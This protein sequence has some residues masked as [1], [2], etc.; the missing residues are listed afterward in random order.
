[1]TQLNKNH[2]I[3]VNINYEDDSSEKDIIIKQNKNGEIRRNQEFIL[4][5]SYGND[6]IEN[7]EMIDLKNK[8]LF[9]GT[10]W[11]KR[12]KIKYSLEYEFS[13]TIERNTIIK[14]NIE[15]GENIN[16]NETSV[17]ITISKGKAIKV[18]NLLNMKVEDITNWVMENKLKISFEEIYDEK[19]ET[20]KVIKANVNE[21]D[22]I[23][24]GFEIILTI[25]KGQIKMQK[26]NSLY[27]FKEWAN[28]YNIAYSESYEYS[29]TVSKGSVISYSYKE[30]EIIN[31][32]DVIY[33]KVSLGKSI[34]IPSFIGKTK[35]EA[36]NI[37][38]SIGIRC[39]FTTGTYTNYNQNVVY[40]QSKNTGT[41]VGSGASITLT[42]SKGI[43]Q[44]K[45]LSILQNWISIGNADAT[46]ASLK[47][48]FNEYY[49]GVNFNFIKVKDNT[50]N[51][52]MIAKNSPTNS[53]TPVK[54]GNT[55]T[56]YV[57]SN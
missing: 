55:Y 37:C 11:L 29:N 41:T 21:N 51:S 12:N 38:N 23:E 6:E 7:I 32:D 19:I 22:S 50:L 3:N 1:M 45:N 36:N 2:M 57:V 10:L 42:L 25:S 35:N 26:F 43:P 44:T 4:T 49:P 39:S 30:N 34:T 13:D 16:V 5:V 52:G 48:N 33:I 24:Q 17:T 28:K 8:T 40:A 56:I 18:P 46:I 27:E 47:N 53:G 20:G 31:P 15:I 14:Q 9:D 54:Q